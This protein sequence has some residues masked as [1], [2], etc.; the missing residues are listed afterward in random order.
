MQKFRKFLAYLITERN[1]I[2]NSPIKCYLP[3]HRRRLKRIDDKL[4][5]MNKIDEELR[6]KAF[7]N[8]LR[9]LGCKARFMMDVRPLQI[10]HQE[11]FLKYG[12][13]LCGPECSI[14]KM[15]V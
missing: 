4:E 15:D 14:S 13:C 1:K 9:A 7:F 12:S 2:L 3:S 8:D 11:Q 10:I 6:T 5:I